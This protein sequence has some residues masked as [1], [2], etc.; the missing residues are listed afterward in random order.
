LKEYVVERVGYMLLTMFLIA[1]LLFFLFRLVPGDPTITVISPQM[2]QA[3]IDHLRHIFGLDR[4]LWEQY[5]IFLKNMATLDFGRSFSSGQEVTQI[6]AYR[7]VNTLL[8]MSVGMVLALVLGVGFG[9]VM[10]WRRG[11]ALDIGGTI[12]SLVFQ[13][14][15]P[16][17]TGLLLLIVFSYRLHWFPIGGMFAPG[18]RPAN[19]FRLLLEPDFYYRLVLPTVTLTS[20]YLATPMLIMRDGMLEVMSSDYVDF[21]K[22]KGLS[23]ARVMVRHAAR[24]ALMGV[25]TVASITIGFAIGGQVIV[26]TLF[27]WPG[28]GQ[29]MVEAASQHDYPV[30][31]ASFLVLAAV[32][33]VLNLLT[34][35]LYG[36]LDPRIKLSS[37]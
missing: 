29:L 31:L 24:N 28:M 5:L 17:I 3:A 30:A 37:Q 36:W 25:V 15:P 1:T 4:P 20:Y 35:L 19:V 7:L 6:I 9:T 21:A 26:E 14:A 10:A 22:A 23:P 18:T 27:S 12:A 32:V 13:S 8:L 33:V 34:D 11:G 16:F 2:D